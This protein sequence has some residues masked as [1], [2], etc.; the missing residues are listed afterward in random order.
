MSRI[1]VSYPLLGG[2]DE[3]EIL[4]HLMGPICAI[5]ADT[6][7]SSGFLLSPPNTYKIVFSVKPSLSVVYDDFRHQAVLWLGFCA[8]DAADRHL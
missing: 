7:H 3:P 2:Y 5:G 4:L 1:S 6:A 8:W